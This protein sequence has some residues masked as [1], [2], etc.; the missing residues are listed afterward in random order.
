MEEMPKVMRHC[1]A[2]IRKA[3]PREPLLGPGV[4]NTTKLL[5]LKINIILNVYSELYFQDFFYKL[6][7]YRIFVWERKW[8]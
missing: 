4:T 6:L 1:G 7:S 3:I 5:H 2:I 8:L